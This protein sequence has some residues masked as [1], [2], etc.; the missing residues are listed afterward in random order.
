[1]Q[2]TLTN[3]RPAISLSNQSDEWPEEAI[4]FFK[5]IVNNTKTP[6][7]A[8]VFSVVDGVSSLEMYKPGRYVK[9]GDT[10]NELLIQEGYA[11]NST[12]SFLSNEDHERRERA[13]MIAEGNY[14]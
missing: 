4:E 12:E 1:M 10:I 2:C 5:N 3:I 14:I 8:M 13:Q 9:T 11:R 6:L 7:Y